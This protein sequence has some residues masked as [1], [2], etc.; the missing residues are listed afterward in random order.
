MKKKPFPPQQQEQ[1][2]VRAKM[3]PKPKTQGGDYLPAGKLK[4]KVAL[5]TGGDSGIGRA[6]AIAFAK[7]AA[8]IAILYLEE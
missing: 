2:G 3:D 6:V 4:D 8:D 5:I 7:E 1:P